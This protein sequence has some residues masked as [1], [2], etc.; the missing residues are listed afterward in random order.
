MKITFSLVPFGKNFSIQGKQV[1]KALEALSNIGYKG[2]DGEVDWKRSANNEIWNNIRQLLETYELEFSCIL[3]PIN[4]KLNSPVPSLR[5]AS[6]KIAKALIDISVQLG[7]ENVLIGGARLPS[8]VSVEKVWDSAVKAIREV[9]NY[10]LDKGVN[11]VFEYWNRFETNFINNTDDT[12]K[13]IEDVGS[14]GLYAVLDTF[15]MNIEEKSFEEPIKKLGKKLKYVHLSESNRLALGMGHINFASV[16]RA[17]KEIGYDGPMCVEIFYYR[18]RDW[19]K[20]PFSTAVNY[21]RESMEFI[22]RLQV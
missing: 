4:L 6:I 22:R 8:K 12:I 5:E 11:L 2:V 17:L 3:G 20:D 10:A 13:L 18:N 14:E 16:L 1:G 7:C 19:P 21:A 15:H 9:A